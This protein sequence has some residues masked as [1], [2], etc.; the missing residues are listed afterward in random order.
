MQRLAH[1]LRRSGLLIYQDMLRCDLF[2]H[3]YAM[4]YVTLFSLVPSLAAVFSLVSLFKPF[5]GQ[6]NNPVEMLK[7]LT[8]K[9][10]AEGSGSE[11]IAHIDGFIAN[12]DITK[13]GLTGFA[14]MLITLILLLKQIEVAFNRIFQI[15]EPRNILVRFVYFWTFLTLG[16]FIISLSVGILAGFNASN[17]LPW[18]GQPVHQNPLL[19]SLFAKSGTFIFF[20]LLYKFVPN[21]YVPL[22]N[23]AIGSAIAT[24]LLDLATRF[25]GV[26]TGSF[27]NYKA[28]YGA[29]AAVPIFLFWIYILWVITLL[30]SVLTW[31]SQQGFSTDAR[32]A[33]PDANISTQDFQ[34]NI[35]IQSH[36]P[37]VLLIAIHQRFQ[38]ADFEHKGVQGDELAQKLALPSPWVRQGLDFLLKKGLIIYAGAEGG[39][40]LFDMM[41][42]KYFPSQPA[43][44]VLISDVQSKLEEDFFHW[45]QGWTHTW[46][47][48]MTGV[49]QRLNT[50]TSLK[51][52]MAD[53]LS[54]PEML[55]T[56]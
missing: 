4:A 8:M 18:G 29:L 44:Q 37:L 40:T 12:L 52:S 25:Y 13:I 5:M 27:T 56:N 15:N 46:P 41:E 54:N 10:L 39:E 38:N 24:L 34:R 30:G 1:D 21:C 48:P 3:A 33:S 2:K 50:K 53:L 19:A 47:Y 9:H 32:L 55:A 6:D 16:T 22:K 43:G 14:G 28:V 42:V 23:A 45:T 26:Y 51:A 20:S 49:I 35:L 17:L 31:R 7:D 11:V 36:V